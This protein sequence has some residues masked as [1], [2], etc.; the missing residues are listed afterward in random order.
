MNGLIAEMI[1]K[2]KLEKETIFFIDL[3]DYEAKDQI[4][5]LSDKG[6]KIGSHTM[7]HAFLSEIPTERAEWELSESKKQLEAL[8][9]QKIEWIA[10]P[11]GR[12]NDEVYKIARDIGYKYI[13]STKIFDLEPIKVGL[14]HTTIH[15][16]CPIRPEY[17]EK[18]WMSYF[19]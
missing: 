14:N 16:G 2:H 12:G 5:T 9:G 11:R 4:K 6:F 1:L 17:Q 8:T 15:A 3:R 19:Y 13:R 7:T 10:L 18:D